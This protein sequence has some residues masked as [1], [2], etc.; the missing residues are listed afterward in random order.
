MN[1]ILR[2]KKRRKKQ[3]GIHDKFGAD[4]RQSA[5]SPKQPLLKRFMLQKISIFA[6]I[7]HQHPMIFFCKLFMPRH[8]FAHRFGRAPA[9][10]AGFVIQAPH[11]TAHDHAGRFNVFISQI[12]H[13]CAHSRN[14]PPSDNL[15][16]AAK[17]GNQRIDGL[18]RRNL[19]NLFNRFSEIFL[20][21][22][23]KNLFFQGSTLLFLCD[24]HRINLQFAANND[25]TE[26]MFVHLQQSAG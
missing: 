18:P 2:L 14:C 15:L 13:H 20:M 4:L 17:K 19:P 10:A 12:S 11:Q 25:R 3:R 1:R 8:D 7:R 5:K 16:G 6:D 9:D 26:I 22:K 21:K 23:G 24:V